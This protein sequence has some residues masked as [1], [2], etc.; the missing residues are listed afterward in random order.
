MAPGAAAGGDRT[1]GWRG[2]LSRRARA[3]RVIGFRTAP[4]RWSPLAAHQIGSGLQQLRI[5]LTDNDE[6]AWIAT[7]SQPAQK[8]D[9]VHARH[10]EIDDQQ[11]ETAVPRTADFVN[12]LRR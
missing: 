2:R 5:D 4:R 7:R 9:A 3:S 12:A 8:L 1:T 10:F 6:I 11:I